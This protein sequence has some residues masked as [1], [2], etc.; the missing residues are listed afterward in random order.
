MFF[1]AVSVSKAFGGKKPP[2]HW[3]STGPLPVVWIPFPPLILCRQPLPPCHCSTCPAFAVS[4]KESQGRD[5]GELQEAG[6]GEDKTKGLVGLQAECSLSK[7]N[8]VPS[9]VAS[10]LLAAWSSRQRAGLPSFS[11]LGPWTRLLTSACSPPPPFSL[12]NPMLS[13]AL[14]NW[15]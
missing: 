3:R 15:K 9:Q 12:P 14:C 4:K 11:S 7:Y 8:A 2:V 6:T 10:G 5:S 13:S 1:S